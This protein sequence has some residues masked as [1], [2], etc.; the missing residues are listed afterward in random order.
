[1]IKKTVISAIAVVFMLGCFVTSVALAADAGPATLSLKSSGKMKKPAVTFGHKK[2]QEKFKC[3]ECH[4]VKGADGKQ[5]P[6]AEGAKV[7]KCETCHTKGFGKVDSFKKAAHKKC[8]GC[9]KKQEDKKL[10]KC[11]TCH[12]K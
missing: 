7:Q 11:K 10:T 3:V 6:L 4:H 1:M 8:K 2:H 9:H 12:K 5:A